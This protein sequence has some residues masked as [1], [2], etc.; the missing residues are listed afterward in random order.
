MNY[1]H[2]P[3]ES[4]GEREIPYLNRFLDTDLMRDNDIDGPED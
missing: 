4:E 2:V 3:V 1:E